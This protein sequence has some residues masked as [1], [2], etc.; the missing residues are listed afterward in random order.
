VVN[1]ASLA[2]YVQTLRKPYP[3]LSG[4][5]RNMV[6]CKKQHGAVFVRI[7]ITG[8]GIE[9]NYLVTSNRSDPDGFP[10]GIPKFIVAYNGRTHEPFDWEDVDLKPLSWSRELLDGAQVLALYN[11]VNGRTG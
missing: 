7:G 11:E 4:M 1:F 5:L 9:P 10:E 2:E 3:Y 8:K 6:V